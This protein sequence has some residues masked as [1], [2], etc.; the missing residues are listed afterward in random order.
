MPV[1]MFV[2]LTIIRSYLIEGCMGHMSSG[3]LFSISLPPFLPQRNTCKHDLC[4]PA[5]F[6]DK[7]LRRGYFD[8]PGKS[9]R[10]RRWGEKQ[11]LV[12][13]VPPL[14]RLQNLRSRN[15]YRPPSSSSCFS[16]TAILHASSTSCQCL[17]LDSRSPLPPRVLLPAPKPPVLQVSLA[18][19]LAGVLLKTPLKTSSIAN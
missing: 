11:Y 2:Y 19:G 8:A 14:R 15:S 17:S 7:P 12:S 18:R 5:T 10:E 9:A 3:P 16:P 13:R 1:H 6:R 4:S